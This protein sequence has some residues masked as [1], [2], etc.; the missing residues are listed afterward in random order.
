MTLPSDLHIVPPSAPHTH[1]IIFLHGR[2]STANTFCNELF[3]SQDSYDRFFVDIFPSVKWVFPCAKKIWAATEGEEMHQ[4]FDMVSVQ[5][6]QEDVEVQRPGLEESAGELMNIIRKEVDVVGWDNV[7]LAGISQGCATAI[8]TLL[9]SQVRVGGFIGLCGWMPLA[10]EVEDEMEAWGSDEVVFKTPVLLQH[11][12]EDV[13]VPIANGEDLRD[14]L[15]GLG[16][17]V[18]WECF[19]DGGLSPAHWMNEPEGMN[20]V[21]QFIQAVIKGSNKSAT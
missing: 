11:C 16:M 1:T 8:Y 2:G 7:I 12:R 5:D 3:E 6:P 4:W 10:K 18:R 15:M 17:H 20:S 14:R 19:E 9:M 13:V 21:V